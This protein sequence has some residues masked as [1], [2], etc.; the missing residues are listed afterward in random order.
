M[1]A[2]PDVLLGLP[3]P[4][5]RKC[6]RLYFH[7]VSCDALVHKLLSPPSPDTVC[8]PL[9]GRGS[10][11]LSYCT[12]LLGA[13]WIT[14]AR[15]G[16]LNVT[17]ALKSC[18][19]LLGHDRA[20]M[21]IFWCRHVSLCRWGMV[22]FSP[23]PWTAPLSNLPPSSSSGPIPEVRNTSGTRPAPTL[24]PSYSGSLPALDYSSG[25]CF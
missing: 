4:H 8:W 22:R 14:F 6:R 15:C 2:Q 11:V 3:P 21:P 10:L 24:Q 16:G 18:S 1:M 12:L 25:T 13:S 7:A 17:K 23:L 9:P 19:L 5:F 20:P